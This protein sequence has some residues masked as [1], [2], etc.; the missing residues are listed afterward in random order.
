MNFVFWSVSTNYTKPETSDTL[1]DDLDFATGFYMNNKAPVTMN[2]WKDMNQGYNGHFWYSL[3]TLKLMDS[4]Y[5]TWT[6][7][8]PQTGYYEVSAYIPFSQAEAAKYK[9]NSL[10]GLDS[11]VINQ[12]EYKDVW[13]SLGKYQFEKGKS[14]Y[15]RLGD[16]STIAGEAIVFDAMK[17]SYIDSTET[18]IDEK[19][20]SSPTE[21]RLEQNYP[22]PFNPA[23]KIEFAIPSDNKVQIRVF[24]VL[25]KEVTTLLNE[26]KK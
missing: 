4:C 17:W 18:A 14:G 15:V 19:D 5:A 11:V 24:N 12:M 22:N 26:Y 25:G 1:I 2:S 20:I 23:T 21:F 13:V 7:N 6:P 8:I 9:I 10:K 16:A 3:T